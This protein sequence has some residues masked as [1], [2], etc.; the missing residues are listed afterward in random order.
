MTKHNSGA[1][2]LQVAYF[3]LSLLLHGSIAEPLYKHVLSSDGQPLRFVPRPGYYSAFRTL[4][5]V[6]THLGLA[7]HAASSSHRGDL[8]HGAYAHHELKRWGWLAH[9][10]A[11]FGHH[12][13]QDPAVGMN[14]KFTYS[15]ESVDGDHSCRVF[16]ARV[17]GSP[18]HDGAKSEL[19]SLYS[20][21]AMA[22]GH[23]RVAEHGP[24]TAVHG[25]TVGGDATSR[26][27]EMQVER[28][29]GE[30]TAPPRVLGVAQL[31]ENIWRVDDVLSSAIHAAAQHGTEPPFHLNDSIAD[32]STLVLLQHTVDS[33]TPFALEWTFSD[34]ELCPGRDLADVEG[35]AAPCATHTLHADV[36]D[37]AVEVDSSALAWHQRKALFHERL[38]ASLGLCEGRDGVADEEH[39]AAAAAVG[40]LLGSV[41]VYSGSQLVATPGWYETRE[42]QTLLTGCPSRSYFPRGFLWDE[43]FHQLIVGAVNP[44]LARAVIASWLDTA[45]GDTGYISRE[46]ILGDE[47]RNRVHPDFWV[48]FRDI[49][50]PPTL[51]LAVAALA[52]DGICLASACRDGGAGTRTARAAVNADGSVFD[53]EAAVDEQGIRVHQFCSHHGRCGDGGAAGP[54][55]QWDCYDRG[56]HEAEPNEDGL[57]DMTSTTDETL[58]FMSD[59][60]PKLK[61]HLEWF[62]RTQAGPRENTFRWRGS[63]IG[64]DQKVWHHFASGLDDYPR[65]LEATDKDENADLLAWMA[66]AATVLGDIA[67]LLGREDDV[68]TLAEHAAVWTRGL[69]EYWDDER[70][71]FC[72]HGVV[73]YEAEAGDQRRPIMGRVCHVG[74]VSL[75]PLLFRLL[76]PSD[77]RIGRLLDVLED[78]AH[79]WSAYGL[80]ALSA[81]DPL[82]CIEETCEPPET[83]TD[84]WRSSIWAT[85]NF[86][87][88][89]ALRYYARQPGPFAS[90]ADDLAAKIESAY[91]GNVV[92]Q[93]EAGG[94]LYE[95]YSSSNGRGRGTRPFTGFTALFV[96]M[97]VKRYP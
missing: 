12:F 3:T 47:A 7:W 6:P 41:T 4:D 58:A 49:A 21:V 59:V 54:R 78:P 36:T 63:R 92:A 86:L 14:L 23:L 16:R 68:A 53:G 90:R 11:G 37:G 61:Q 25:T 29:D 18:A 1:T 69:D 93:Y 65:G 62:M 85:H 67:A 27:L 57:N 88:A 82:Y 38:C 84:Y 79:L 94:F 73:D 52:V 56:T 34:R 22:G 64:G 8:R 75:Y 70:G 5:T 39:H 9:D 32:A 96:L 89:A 80:R 97:S 20:Y 77:E 26:A 55:C 44:R 72:E 17:E 74:Y 91:V 81:S 40:N 15:E 30:A 33:G 42:P 51:F 66:M 2:R 87:A 48:Q 71:V 19:V 31:D 13:L 10:A 43:G 35:S 76:H 45:E 50:N 28:C 95:H 83:A 60:Y 24:I 46:V